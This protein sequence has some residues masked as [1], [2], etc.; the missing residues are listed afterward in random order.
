MDLQEITREIVPDDVGKFAVNLSDAKR[1][2]DE[3]ERLRAENAKLRHQLN[4]R[5]IS[6]TAYGQ[7]KPD[8]RIVETGRHYECSLCGAKADTG[9]GETLDHEIDCPIREAARAAGVMGVSATID[10]FVAFLADHPDA[11]IFVA[12][13]VWEELWIGVFKEYL[14][15]G[16]IVSKRDDP[17]TKLVWSGVHIYRLWV[18]APGTVAAVKQHH[19]SSPTKAWREAFDKIAKDTLDYQI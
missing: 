10:R 17:P 3:N 15:P 14:N 4:R 11:H 13:D 5:F 18:L 9:K 6:C 12:P 8:G 1:L 19:L 16:G 2:L 7:Q